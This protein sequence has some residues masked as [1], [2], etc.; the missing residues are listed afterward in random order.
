MGGI[1]SS[2]IE[3]QLAGL[4]GGQDAEAQAL[5]QKILSGEM[6]AQLMMGQ[7]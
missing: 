5:I 1:P 2:D 3:A 4:M 7:P 6:D